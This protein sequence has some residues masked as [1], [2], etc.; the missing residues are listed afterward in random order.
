MPTFYQ[1]H[2]S[3]TYQCSF[4]TIR[5]HEHTILLRHNI[6]DHYGITV[7]AGSIPV[8]QN[9]Y[10]CIMMTKLKKK[11]RNVPNVE[12]SFQLCLVSNTVNNNTVN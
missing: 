6:S 12:G 9:N 10:L 5:V 11:Q 1:F 2:R 8:G 3:N 4:R 7:A